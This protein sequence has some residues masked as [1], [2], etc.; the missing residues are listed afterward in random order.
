MLR[1]KLKLS[2]ALFENGER[3]TVLIG[4][5]WG[6]FLIKPRGRSTAVEIE[7]AIVVILLSSAS[8]KQ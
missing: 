5:F 1:V 6:E 8:L 7:E 3:L 4:L 2:E